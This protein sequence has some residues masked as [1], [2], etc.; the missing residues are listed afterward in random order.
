MLIGTDR[1]KVLNNLQK[2]FDRV[3]DNYRKLKESEIRLMDYETKQA[4]SR[5][6][7]HAKKE[8]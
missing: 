1:N 8:P 6:R 5:I 7:K 3:F 2:A 4:W